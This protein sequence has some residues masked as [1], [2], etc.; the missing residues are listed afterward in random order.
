MHFHYQRQNDLDFYLY[1]R[2]N[3]MEWKGMDQRERGTKGVLP[4]EL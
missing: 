1:F 2:E 4:G 3:N